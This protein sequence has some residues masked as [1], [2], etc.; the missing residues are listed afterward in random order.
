MKPERKSRLM[1]RIAIRRLMRR[2]R[3]TADAPCRESGAE[4]SGNRAEEAVKVD[5]WR[6]T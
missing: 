5:V 2:H 1:P 3:A 4:E 6:K